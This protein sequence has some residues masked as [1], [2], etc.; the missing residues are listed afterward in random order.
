MSCVPPD[1]PANV[2]LPFCEVGGPV[3]VVGL[4]ANETVKQSFELLASLPVPDPVKFELRKQRGGVVFALAGAVL[5]GLGVGRRR[6]SWSCRIFVAFGLLCGLTV[7]GA[8][9]GSQK[10]LTPGN[11]LYTITATEQGSA[12]PITA[13]ATLTV[14]VPPGVVVKS[15]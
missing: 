14:T 2:T 11:Y 1:E 7:I 9:G 3:I 15:S 4:T 12:S 6:S 10:T 13:T 5:L 8:C